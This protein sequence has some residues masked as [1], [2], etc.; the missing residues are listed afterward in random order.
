MGFFPHEYPDLPESTYWLI[1]ISGAIRLFGSLN[2]Q[3]LSHSLVA[4]R[5]HIPITRITLFI[6]GG[7]AQMDKEPPN[8]PSEIRMAIAGPPA[9]FVLAGLFYGACA[10]EN[11]QGIPL[12]VVAIL[13]YPGCINLVLAV[14]NFWPAFPPPTEGACSTRYHGAGSAIFDGRH[15]WPPTS[16]R[17]LDSFC[18]SWVS[19]ISSTAGH[20]MA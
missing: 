17:V 3:E 10:L 9:G 13:G 14:L 2:L 5:Y 11:L 7:V 15:T 4:R 19:S 6:F 1:G 18:C 12:P 8:A 20:W 16:D